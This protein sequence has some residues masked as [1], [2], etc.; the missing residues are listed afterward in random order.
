MAGNVTFDLEKAFKT[1][2]QLDTIRGP[3]S[4]GIIGVTKQG[5]AETLKRQ[6]TP[7][8]LAESKDFSALFQKQFKALIGHNR[9]A[10]VGAVNTMN[11]HPFSHGSIHGVHNGTLRNKYVLEDARF[12]DVDSDNLYHHINE[13]GFNDAAKI[14]NGAMS[15]AFYD[16]RARKMYLFRNDE[17]PMC[18]AYT[19]DRKSILFASEAWMIRV[20]CGKHG[21]KIDEVYETDVDTLYTLDLDVN[22]NKHGFDIDEAISMEAIDVYEPPAYNP[23]AKYVPK[24]AG[25]VPVE[26]Q[27]KYTGLLGQEIEFRIGYLSSGAAASYLQ[28]TYTRD[29]RIKVRV[30]DPKKVKELLELGSG[31]VCKATTSSYASRDGGYLVVDVDTIEPPVKK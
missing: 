18:F 28:C 1:M 13:Q 11:A 30:Y 19:K 8:D 22:F 14:V 17:R 20:A 12:F 23:P 24:D 31:I 25:G 27:K 3:H 5:K 7:W 2:L 29:F 15:L 4:T 10:T 16:D 26:L 6:G 21:V 9:W